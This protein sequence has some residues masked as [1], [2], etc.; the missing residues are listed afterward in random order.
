MPILV[1]PVLSNV[2]GILQDVVGDGTEEWWYD[3]KVRL[4]MKKEIVDCDANFKL[5]CQEGW[6]FPVAPIPRVPLCAAVRRELPYYVTYPEFVALVSDGLKPCS[7]PDKNDVLRVCKMITAGNDFLAVTWMKDVKK[8]W[9]KTLEPRLAFESAKGDVHYWW[10]WVKS[11][12]GWNAGTYLVLAVDAIG[13]LLRYTF[14]SDGA[15]S[16]DVRR[17]YIRFHNAARQEEEIRF[18]KEEELISG[19]RRMS[20]KEDNMICCEECRDEYIQASRNSDGSFYVEYQLYHMPWQLKCDKV[21][22][23]EFVRLVRLY[24]AGG[25]PA[26]ANECK[27]TCCKRYDRKP[28]D[29]GIALKARLVVAEKLRRTMIAKTIR[30]LGVDERTRKGTFVFPLLVNKNDRPVLWT[31]SQYYLPRSFSKRDR[32]IVEVAAALFD[33]SWAH[34][35]HVAGGIFFEG[36]GVCRDY[37][38]AL[39]WE[40]RAEKL[41]STK[42]KQAIA[43]LTAMLD[44]DRE[45]KSRVL[46]IEHETT[47]GQIRDDFQQNKISSDEAVE[48]VLDDE[49]AFENQLYDGVVTK[50]DA[51]IIQRSI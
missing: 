46:R 40:K 31:T 37:H 3:L 26:I 30:A 11:A 1:R 38:L 45:E 17:F 27:W 49:T 21:S 19:I 39:F 35:A 15:M 12:K 24:Y 41:G 7:L 42:C 25:V 50:E 9:R 29:L 5:R 8:A 23:E 22:V 2:Y 16:D 32:S 13:R 34:Y 43:R 48:R 4:K 33:S 6:F 20:M 51:C 47:L 14:Y 18:H 44:P 36:R 10:C 28:F